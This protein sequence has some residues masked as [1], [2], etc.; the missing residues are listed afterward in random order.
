[1]ARKMAIFDSSLLL[2]HP[3]AI[4][5]WFIHVCFIRNVSFEP[6]MLLNCCLIH[7]N[8][9]LP[10]DFLYLIYLRL[11]YAWLKLYLICMIYYFH[12]QS[13]K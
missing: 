4:I 13:V 7:I 1:M 12:S 9:I 5:A 3:H 10:R 8:I 2:P 6:Q 11:C